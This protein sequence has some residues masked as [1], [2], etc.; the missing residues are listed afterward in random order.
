MRVRL[1]A[2][3]RSGQK[4]VSNTN[5][6]RLLTQHVTPRRKRFLLERRHDMVRISTLS[7]S[8][9]LSLR[10]V[11]KRLMAAP[12]VDGIAEFGSRSAEQ[13]S[14][15]SD[16]DL[17]VLVRAVPAAVF[18]MVTTIDRRLADIVLVDVETAE[19][20]LT[21]A[22]PPQ[23]QSFAGLFAQKMHS[24]H[25]LYDASERLH[26][27]KQLVTG[28]AWAAQSAK[29]RMSPD[30]YGDWFWL[31]FGLLQLE[32]MGS[33]RDPVYEVAVDMMFSAC[34]PATWRAYFA[35]R[36]IPWEGEKAA[37]RFWEEHD[38]AYLGAVRESLASN[39][40]EQKIAAYRNL[41]ELTLNP[42]GRPLAHGET[43][44]ILQ[45][46]NEREDILAVLDFWESLLAQESTSDDNSA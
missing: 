26:K 36:A 4:Y 12:A 39:R 46:R 19:G 31:S 37:I 38:A 3:D 33:A 17:L 14:A 5:A 43:A 16:Y 42:I 40:R 34:L 22:E 24:A 23:P 13:A 10:E 29:G 30:A 28:E 41:V 35:L 2:A 27:V 6:E 1:E 18:Q 11:L 7:S 44:L 21:A 9:E 25:I 8:D 15:W 32:R 20:I 45:G